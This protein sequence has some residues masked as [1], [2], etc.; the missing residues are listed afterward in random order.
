MLQGVQGA[1]IAQ[2]L[3]QRVPGWR[4]TGVSADELAN[5]EVRRRTDDVGYQQRMVA[6]SPEE[7]Q[8][9]QLQV[10]ILLAKQGQQTREDLREIQLSLG[11]IAAIQTRTEMTSQMVA[12]H[13]AAA[14]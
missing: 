9:E 11:H 12:Q 13:K 1:W 8:R 14:R 7:V 4:R 6:A 5:L 3:D 2:Y 10:A